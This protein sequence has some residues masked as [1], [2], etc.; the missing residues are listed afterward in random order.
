VKPEVKGSEKKPWLLLWRGPVVAEGYTDAGRVPEG[1]H[2]AEWKNSWID[3]P[4]GSH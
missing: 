2:L 4:K 3:K 1:T